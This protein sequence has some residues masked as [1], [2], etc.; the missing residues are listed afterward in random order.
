[1]ATAVKL[2]LLEIVT[3]EGKQKQKNTYM[4]AICLTNTII[5]REVNLFLTHKQ[6]YNTLRNIHIYT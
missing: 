2:R 3:K 5:F 6:S 4:K 1:M